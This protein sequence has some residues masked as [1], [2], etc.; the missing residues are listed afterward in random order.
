MRPAGSPIRGFGGIASGPGPLRELHETARA[1]LE[2]N[3][4]QPVSVTTIV[5]IMNLV[6]KCVVAGNVRRTAEIAFGDPR[7]DEYIDLKN[8][9]VNPQRMSY[10]W[11]SNNSVF[12]ELGMDYS[13][14]VRRI[15][16]NG[17]PGFA[18][19][20]NMRSYGRMNGVPDRS[21]WRAS[22]GN[23]CLEQTLESFELCCLVETFPAKHTDLEDFK[24]TLDAAFHYAKTVTLGET[25]WPA[26]NAV[27][28]RNRRIGCSISGVAQFISRCAAPTARLRRARPSARARLNR[29]ARHRR[30]ARVSARRARSRGLGELRE[31]CEAGYGELR[32]IDAKYSHRFGIPRSVKLTSVKPSGSVSLLAGATPGLHFPESRFYVRR[33]RLPRLSPLVERLVAAGLTVEPA[34]GDEEQTLVV[35]FPVDAGEGVRSVHELSMWEQLS[36]AAFLQR[37]WADNQVS[38]TVTFD[39][40]TEASSLASALDYFQYQLKGVSFLPRLADATAYP[41]MPYEKISEEEYEA[42]MARVRMDVLYAEEREQRGAGGARADACAGADAGAALGAPGGRG[43]SGDAAGAGGA[44][45]AARGRKPAAPPSADPT[46]DEQHAMHAADHTPDIFCDSDRCVQEEVRSIARSMSAS[47]LNG[48]GKQSQRRAAAAGGGGGGSL[49]SDS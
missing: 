31:W 35:E 45:W 49:G 33:M 28:R 20:D 19:L 34:V 14:L 7:S 24:R 6:G 17:E 47:G 46:A 38:C 4:G 3:V 12:A 26:T 40:E 23:P 5:D 37:H 42:M 32:D 29:A 9:E 16:A 48:A 21:D 11:T 8:Y 22:G 1:A 44:E 18:W 43:A 39:P 41:Q 36:L 10:G 13:P 15:V 25:Q 30:R 2:R 27:M